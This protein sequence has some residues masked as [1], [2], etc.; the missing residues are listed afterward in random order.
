MEAT[1]EA[2]ETRWDER[3]RRRCARSLNAPNGVGSLPP[4]ARSPPIVYC[5]SSP[6]ES[7]RDVRFALGGEVDVV[8]GEETEKGKVEEVAPES[9]EPCSSSVAAA[10][11]HQA[12]AC[13]VVVARL[14][15]IAAA[16]ATCPAAIVAAFAAAAAAARA[17][18]ATGEWFGRSLST[19][20]AIREV[21][22]ARIEGVALVTS[23][24]SALPSYPFSS[25]SN[26]CSSCRVAYCMQL[27]SQARFW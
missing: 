1:D 8:K 12:K 27:S 25:S 13:V 24:G 17:M 20:D 3:C 23:S 21:K 9:G 6:G 22:S 15:V 4:V 26:F 11:V 7:V 10:V 2:R 5:S 14:F 18:T 19:C 16:E